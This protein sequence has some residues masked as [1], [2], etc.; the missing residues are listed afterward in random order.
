[1]KKNILKFYWF[2]TE[3]GFDVYFQYKLF[4]L[5][6]KQKEIRTLHW[7]RCFVGYDLQSPTYLIYFP[8]IKGIKILRCVKFSDSYDN[9]FLPELSE[10]DLMVL[11]DYISNKYKKKP[12][13]D[14]NNKKEG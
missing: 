9:S 8:E 2:E 12:K 4:L 10:D 13:E 5:C 6:T 3:I 11:S 7:K 1:M 14:Q